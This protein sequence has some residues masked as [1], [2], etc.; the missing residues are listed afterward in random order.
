ML[1]IGQYLELCHL[2]A[3]ELS[4]AEYARVSFERDRDTGVVSVT[5]LPRLRD[6]YK[7]LDGFV[8]VIINEYLRDLPTK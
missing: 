4:E 1:T 2:F 7:D 5:V 8:G 6:G 3:S